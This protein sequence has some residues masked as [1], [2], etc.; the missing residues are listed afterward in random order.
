MDMNLPNKLTLL[1]IGLVPVVVALILYPIVPDAFIINRWLVAG[2][3]FGAA[4]ITDAF[5]GKIARKRGLIT[6]FGK[7]LDPVADKLL[8]VS[9]F[10]AL[11]AEG[12]CSPWIIIIV[13]L[14]EFLVTSMR[15]VEAGK[16]NVIPANGW[17]KAKTIIQ[18]IGIV[19]VFVV[20]YAKYIINYFEI[21]APITIIDI[22]DISA[23]VV[24]WFSAAITL[25]SG[26]IYLKA[27]KEI[28][29]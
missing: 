16:G 2:L 9:A 18:I 12:L 11:M 13:L 25:L 15:M 6:N 10:I 5:D 22:A 28:F 4:A 3:V 26:F 17:G 1:R 23:Q 27:S 8:V 21:P 7:L 14:R 24:L 20:E 19:T 29:E